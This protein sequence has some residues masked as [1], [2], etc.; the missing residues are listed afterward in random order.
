[1]SA[2]RPNAATYRSVETSYHRGLSIRTS[3]VSLGDA[4]CVVVPLLQVAEIKTTGQLL[5]SD[6]A[7]TAVLPIALSRHAERLRQKPVPTI[8]TLGAFW[9]VAQIVTDLVRNSAREDYLRGWLKICFLLVNFTVVWLVVC[10]RQRRFRLYG[11]GLAAGTILS[12][13]LH[14]SDQALISPW[15]F[16]LGIPITMLVAIFAAHVKARRYLGILLPLV[17]LAAIHVLEDFRILAVISFI[18]AIYSLSLTSAKGEQFGRF[19]LIMLGLAVAGGIGGFTLAYSHYAMLGAFGQYAQQKLEAQSG[20]E[21]GLLL[22]GRSEILASSQAI[23]DS[24]FLGHGSWARDPVYAAILADRRA[25]LG[26]KR[27]QGGKQDDLI[28]THSYIFGSWVE[29][30]IAGGIFWLFMLAF[31]IYALLNASGTEPLL[32]LF[33]FAG[34]MLTWDILFSPLG[35]PVR[36]VAPYL[37][38]A[39]VLLR[40]LQNS[41]PAFG[42]EI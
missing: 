7:M 36:F 22:G 35:T 20:G 6:L 10:S 29:A 8:L 19:R 24:P 15:K 26:Y 2:T 32:P 14:P 11:V 4:F 34:F 25:E 42:W 17:A 9:L 5:V 30:G 39:I 23:L 33:A 16:G 40:T 13:Y 31:T 12:V 1:M 3:L 27:F 41:P 28:P 37:M 38:A 21:G 18:T